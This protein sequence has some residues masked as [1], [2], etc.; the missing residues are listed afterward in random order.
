[1]FGASPFAI[2]EPVGSSAYLADAER[3]HHR[4]IKALGGDDIRDRDGDMIEHVTLWDRLV[5]AMGGKDGS[6]AAGQIGHAGPTGGGTVETEDGQPR[7]ETDGAID[8][9]LGARVDHR[10]VEHRRSGRRKTSS[11]IVQPAR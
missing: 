5:V 11:A 9:H 7:L 10:V 1:M 6:M 2:A 8:P 4:V 3:H